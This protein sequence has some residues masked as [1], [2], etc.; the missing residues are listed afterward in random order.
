MKTATHQRTNSQLVQNQKLVKNK[1]KL[2][3]NPNYNKIFIPEKKTSSLK[4]LVTEIGNQSQN[5]PPIKIKRKK[6]IKRKIIKKE[7]KRKL[8]KKMKKLKKFTNFQ[9]ISIN[10][11]IK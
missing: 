9:E 6:K 5:K 10:I 7:K 8:M 11:I 3:D 4:L 2:Y 1:K